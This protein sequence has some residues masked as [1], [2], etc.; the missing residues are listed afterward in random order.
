MNELLRDRYTLSDKSKDEI[1]KK[2][3]NY[4]KRRVKSKDFIIKGLLQTIKEIK[5]KSVSV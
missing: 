4:I 5:T 2:G 1:Y 3:N